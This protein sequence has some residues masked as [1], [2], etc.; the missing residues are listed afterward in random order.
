[1]KPVMQPAMKPAMKP[2]MQPVMKPAVQPKPAMQSKAMRVKAPCESGLCSDVAPHDNEMYCAPLNDEEEDDESFS[3]INENKLK[4]LPLRVTEDGRIL[5]RSMENFANNES[6][7]KDTLDM[8]N[9]PSAQ[10]YNIPKQ[11]LAK[12]TCRPLYQPDMVVGFDTNTT[13]NNF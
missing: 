4:P 9:P 5:K 8:S 13:Y 2:V 10:Y 3:N 11:C 7:M 6:C 12:D 1:M